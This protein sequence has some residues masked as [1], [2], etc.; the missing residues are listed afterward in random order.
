MSFGAF[1]RAQR[2]T[3]GVS[4]NELAKRSGMHRTSI[5]LLERGERHDPS[6]DTLVKLARALDVTP[7]D[8][9]DDYAQQAGLP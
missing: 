1:L 5:S 2:R 7:S 8:F 3:C 9:V 6:L 4:Q